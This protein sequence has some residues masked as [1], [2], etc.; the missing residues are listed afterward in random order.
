MQ[1]DIQAAK[2]ADELANR[3]IHDH[4]TRENTE[5]DTPDQPRGTQAAHHPG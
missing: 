4:P 3:I 1:I 5:Y 2:D